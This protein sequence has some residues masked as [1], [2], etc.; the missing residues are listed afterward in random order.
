VST[1]VLKPRPPLRAFSVAAALAL[2]G[3]GFFAAPDLFGWSPVLRGIGIVFLVLGM[4]ILVLGMLAMRRMRVEVVLDQNGYQV[5]GPVRAS[6]GSWDEVTRVTRAN[7]QVI[8]YGRDG[9]RTVI[10]LPRG[11]AGDLNAL[12]TDIARLLDA[13]RGYGSVPLGIQEPDAE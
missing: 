7:Q 8:L 6:A 12:G 5:V 9:T 1:H 3:I 2:V 13:H 10:A 11:A 4:V